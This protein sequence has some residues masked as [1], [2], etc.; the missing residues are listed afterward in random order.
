MLK[1]DQLT[2]LRPA[3]RY[4]VIGLINSLVSI[5]TAHDGYWSVTAIVTTAVT[6]T[7]SVVMLG[8][9]LIYKKQHKEAKEEFEQ[10]KTQT[11][12]QAE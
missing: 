11:S 12:E 4:S 1:L 8:L 3:L 2:S 6:G 9:Y 7:C 5:Y 10:E